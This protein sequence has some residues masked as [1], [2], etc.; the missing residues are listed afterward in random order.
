MNLC[1]FTLLTKF[2]QNLDIS[3][4]KVCPILKKLTTGRHFF[5][6]F[7]QISRYLDNFYQRARSVHAGP[8][9][10]PARLEEQGVGWEPRTFV[11]FGFVEAFRS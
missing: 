7:G 6:F 9:E 5:T 4:F 1:P 10:H 3:L 8:W 11:N 2:G